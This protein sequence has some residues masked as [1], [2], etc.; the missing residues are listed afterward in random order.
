MTKRTIR[1]EKKVSTESL[2]RSSSIPFGGDAWIER[3]TY[4]EASSL[5]RKS[6]YWSP[7]LRVWQ[8]CI[9][10]VCCEKATI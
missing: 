2:Q 7:S 4:E 6:V 8:I 5:A 1:E 9:I 10:V 3:S